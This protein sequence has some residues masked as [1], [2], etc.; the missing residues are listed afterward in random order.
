[1]EYTSYKAARDN[2]WR[3]LIQNDITTLPVPISTICKA[4]GIL[5][6]PYSKAGKL[7]REAGMQQVMKNDGF[8]LIITN[9]GQKTKC[10]F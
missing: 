9:S 6:L 5:L 2:A 10:I 7:L 3:A 4:D 1:M 8:S